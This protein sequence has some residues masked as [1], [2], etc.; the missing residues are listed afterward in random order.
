MAKRVL[1]GNGIWLSDKLARVEPV[2][3]RPE[4]TWIYPI[5]SANGTFEHNLPKIFAMCYG[6]RPDMTMEKLE[7]MFAVFERE[8]LIF[9]WRDKATDQFWGFFTGCRK[10]GRLPSQSR[11]QKGHELVGP[12]PPAEALEK[13]LAQ[14]SAPASAPATVAIAASKE[15]IHPVWAA[16]GARVPFGTEQFQETIQFYF[17]NRGELRVSEALEQ[18]IQRCQKRKL[19]IPPQLYTLKRT[20]EESEGIA[21]PALAGHAAAPARVTTLADIRPKER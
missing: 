13:F 10:P 15:S 20:V 6:R 14:S 8:R 12:E 7:D 19:P 5:A 17:E 1:D 9:K 16:I 21:Q 11:V 2:W 4:Y 18:G 3:C